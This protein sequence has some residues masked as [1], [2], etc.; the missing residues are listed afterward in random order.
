MPSSRLCSSGGEPREWAGIALLIAGALVL[1]PPLL[2][3][4]FTTDSGLALLYPSRRGIP[5]PGAAV[6][7]EFP[8]AATREV[9][10][11]VIMEDY[12]RVD[13]LIKTAQPDLAARDERGQ[14]LLGI[15][16]HHAMIYS[17]T[18][19]N[20]RPLRALLA[21][22]AVPRPDD[23]GRDELM[24]TKLARARGEPASAAFA[25]LL[26]AGLSPDERDSEGQSVLFDNYLTPEAARVLVAHGVS[27]APTHQRGA[28]GVVTRDVAG[29]AWQLGHRARP[30]RG[31]DRARLRDAAGLAVCPGD[32][33]RPRGCIRRRPCRCR[34]AGVGGR[35]GAG[36]VRRRGG[37]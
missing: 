13:S 36:E 29:G 6:R 2:L 19:E 20:L 9:A 32:G 15:A 12:A 34:H 33:N 26:E 25:M 8:D 7:Y 16:T 22:G 14:S 10:L 17:A 28:A 3:I 37:G 11:A 30:A 4:L 18:M 24:I 27:R 5:K 31:G 1:L 23:A 35:S 21:A